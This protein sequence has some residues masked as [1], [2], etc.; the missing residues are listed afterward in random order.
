[1]SGLKYKVG[2]IVELIEPINDSLFAE[3]VTIDIRDSTCPYQICQEYTD[4]DDV[5]YC[6]IAEKDI[7]CLVR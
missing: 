7:E 5:I 1:M 4:C 2:D 3:I 6:W